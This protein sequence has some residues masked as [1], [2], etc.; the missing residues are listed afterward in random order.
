MTAASDGYVLAGESHSPLTDA[1]AYIVKVDFNGNLVWNKTVGGSQADSASYIGTTFDGGYLVCG[2]TFSFGAGNRDFWLLKINNV[3]QIIF[4]CTAGDVGFQEAYAVIDEGGNQY[5]MAGWTDPAG[6]PDLV[7]KATYDWWIVKLSPV[8][9]SNS[10]LSNPLI[11][12]TSAITFAVL[13]ATLLL[14]LKMRKT[15]NK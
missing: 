9:I 10:A 11:I 6:H 8:G 12:A 5:V 7:G 4:S 15:K 1:D 2:F 3:G 13:V 14:L